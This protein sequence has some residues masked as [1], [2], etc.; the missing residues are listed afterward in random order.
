M[1]KI[2]ANGGHTASWEEVDHPGE[3]LF[4]IVQ[5]DDVSMAAESWLVEVAYTAVREPEA[6]AEFSGRWPIVYARLPG[7]RAL[8]QVGLNLV[9]EPAKDGSD[10]V[11]RTLVVTSLVAGDKYKFGLE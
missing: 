3:L 6:R 9:D 11:V 2:T 7:G 5:R 4:V 1:N 8:E 10:D